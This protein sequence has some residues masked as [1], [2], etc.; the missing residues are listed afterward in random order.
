MNDNDFFK[1]QNLLPNPADPESLAYFLKNIP[2]ISKK[3]IGDYLAR[4]KHE[5]VLKAFI[6]L[7]DFSGVSINVHTFKRSCSVNNYIETSG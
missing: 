6:R 7:N 4:P 1:G 2:K 3:L 5:D